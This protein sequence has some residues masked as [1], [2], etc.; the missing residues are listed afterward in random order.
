MQD[1]IGITAASDEFSALVAFL[2]TWCF[3]EPRRSPIQRQGYVDSRFVQFGD[4][5]RIAY[6]LGELLNGIIFPFRPLI[7]D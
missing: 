3:R 5:L 6:H 4:A 2:Q 7:L 1:A